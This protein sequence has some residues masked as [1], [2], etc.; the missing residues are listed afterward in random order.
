MTTE[1]GRISNVSDTA[2]WVAT[3]RAMETE[4]PDAIFNDPFA[5][6]LAG[7]AGEAIVERMPQG[8]QMAWAMIV[9]TAVFDEII[10]ER[11]RDGGID[12][13][14]NLAAGL[15]ARPWRLPLPSSLRWVD[16]DFPAM[17][18]HKTSALKDD[19]PVCQYE[20]VAADLSDEAARPAL[21]A[22]VTAGASRVLVISEG[23]LIYLTEDQVASL[24]RDLA[25]VPAIREWLIDLA[26]PRLLAWMERRWAAQQNMGT[27]KFQFA[28]AAGTAFFEPHGWK[29][30][31]FVSSSDS[32][33]RLKREMRGMWFW[34]LIG[35][36]YPAH[37]REQ[38]RRFS[39]YVLLTRT[40][41]A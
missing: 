6:K 8:R 15:D 18:E 4:R 19:T 37:V 34:R 7:E 17:I 9:R 33:R 39:G 41:G 35:R 1:R 31:R 5:R 23:L 36:L 28:P 21:F 30:E 10:L 40:G 11:I 22:K 38:F 14:L 13:I 3:Y 20:A 25:A 2:L 27:A 12:L 24:A 32:A 26:S 16:V 29:E